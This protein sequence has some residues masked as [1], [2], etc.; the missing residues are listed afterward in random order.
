PSSARFTDAQAAERGDTSCMPSARR[1]RALAPTPL[2]LI[3]EHPTVSQDGINLA[4]TYYRVGRPA[5][6]RDNF[7]ATLEWYDRAL[8]ALQK[9]L[10]HDP[11]NDMASLFVASVRQERAEVL[12]ALGRAAEALRTFE[13]AAK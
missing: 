7:P 1:P 4:V 9:V 10:Q 13:E 3:R 6:H 2:S 8:W 11:R 12:Y 5:R